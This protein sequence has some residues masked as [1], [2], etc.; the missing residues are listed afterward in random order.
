MSELGHIKNKEEAER[1]LHYFILLQSDIMAYNKALLTEANQELARLLSNKINIEKAQV[2][3]FFHFD[4][5]GMFAYC[6][7]RNVHSGHN[8]TIGAY[9]IAEGGKIQIR[10]DFTIVNTMSAWCPLEDVVL[11]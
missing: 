6:P 9:L 3:H 2:A 8:A 5:S 4:L 1:T 7:I 10:L 11:G